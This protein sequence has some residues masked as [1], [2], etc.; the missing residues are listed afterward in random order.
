MEWEVPYGGDNSWSSINIYPSTGNSDT[1]RGA[2]ACHRNRSANAPSPILFW[3]VYL[4]MSATKR[5]SENV[6]ICCRGEWAKL[7]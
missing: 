1:I 3:R 2:G 4:E 6:E 7:R 5:I